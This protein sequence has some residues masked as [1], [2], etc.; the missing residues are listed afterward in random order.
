MRM[1]KSASVFL[2]T[3]VKADWTKLAQMQSDWL[4]LE[5]EEIWLPE[6]TVADCF[7]F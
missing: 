6:S 3:F 4:N 5:Y 2:V 1:R 7:H